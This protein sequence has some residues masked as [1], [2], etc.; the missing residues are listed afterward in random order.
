MQR[1]R[2]LEQITADFGSLF[3][4][5]D[6]VYLDHKYVSGGNERS[7]ADLLLVLNNECIVI[8]L[9]GTDGR[10]KSDTR[11]KSWLT[12]QHWY[13][14]KEAKTTIQR[15]AK[16]SSTARNLWNE[17]KTFEP[18]TLGAKCGV[19]LLECSQKPFGSIEFQIKQ[20]QSNVPVHFLS[21]NDFLN[22][23]EWL[24]SIW[25]IFNYF[26]KRTEVCQVFTGI[27]QEQPLLAYYTLRSKDL[28]GFLEEDK[29][30]LAALHSLHLME[31]LTE[32]NERDRLLGYI[33]AIVHELH[34][35]HPS[36]ESFMPPEFMDHVEPLEKRASYLE[37]AAILNA[38]P[39]SNKVYLG[40][41]I[42]S[43]L[44]DLRNSGKAGCF[45]FK[46]LVG[47]LVFV[48]T[49]F[50]KLSRTERIRNLNE[51]LPAALYQYNTTDGLAVAFDAD[52]SKSGFDLMWVRNYRASSEND[53][54][55]G[56]FLFPN[57]KE[58]LVAN[59]FGRPRP[60][61]PKNS[62]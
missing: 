47:K 32:Y 25:D 61:K 15:L 23:V 57:P 41:N 12:K 7:L 46:P 13:G 58:T 5:K 22:V 39:A 50:S 62:G 1:G 35:R 19:V 36:I 17:E 2:L 4:M 34:T 10:I 52:E 8:S 53:R 42:E 3:F 37:M 43:M 28:R 21:L 44:K 18:G 29:Q 54:R 30:K 6:F 24:G 31:N 14:S 27:N 9:K 55:L 33:N 48:F 40:R 59:P 51:I 49:F 26:S 20:L 45:A 16:V 60:Y 56:E 11:L 38:L